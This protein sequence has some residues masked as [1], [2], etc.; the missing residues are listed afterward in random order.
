VHSVD[1]EF[2]AACRFSGSTKDRQ[3]TETQQSRISQ[4][5]VIR[6]PLP[7]ELSIRKCSAIHESIGIHVG[8]FNNIG[9]IEVDQP[10]L[11]DL[12]MQISLNN[13]PWINELHV[14][15]MVQMAPRPV[16]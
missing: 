10:G 13:D 16:V 11:F 12:S 2:G 9:K 5:N 3:V 8:E 4:G 15:T 7:L 1:Q 6:L 14:G